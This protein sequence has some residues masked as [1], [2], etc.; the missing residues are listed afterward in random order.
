MSFEVVNRVCFADHRLRNDGKPDVQIE[1]KPVSAEVR[2]KCG[3]SWM[4]IS[5]F[6]FFSLQWK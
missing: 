1:K 6:L 5:A 2:S 4:Q 3:Q